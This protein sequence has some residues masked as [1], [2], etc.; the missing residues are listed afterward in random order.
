MPQNLET[1][2]FG[3]GCFWCTEAIFQRVEGVVTVTS[4]YAGGTKENPTYEEVSSGSTGHAEVL[5]V[6]YD[7]EKID[8]N[9][10][11]KIFFGTHDYKSLNK[12]GSDVGTQY[13]SII[14]YTNEPQRE[15]I[16]DFMRN[17]EGAVTE[18]K[19]IDKFYK[20]EDYHQNFYDSNPEVP[21]CKLVIAPKLDK[22]FK[23]DKP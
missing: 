20:A 11:L 13:R 10:L 7:P 1:I 8:F 2:Y 23:S 15:M 12:Q 4:G 19:P 21:Y 17:L 9:N 3:G 22:L 14:L 18:V 16:I 6:D 5:Q